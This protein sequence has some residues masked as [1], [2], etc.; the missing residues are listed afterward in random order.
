MMI[1][2]PVLF[3]GSPCACWRRCR[4]RAVRREREGFRTCPVAV[5]PDA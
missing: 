2:L 4:W 1:R 5:I 3:S